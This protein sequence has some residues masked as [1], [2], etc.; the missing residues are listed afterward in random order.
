MFSLSRR[1]I[2]LAVITCIAAPLIARADDVVAS[3]VPSAA[4][5]ITS[6][7]YAP[8]EQ[9]WSVDA[10]R[11]LVIRASDGVTEL[12]RGTLPPNN[13]RQIQVLRDGSFI[14]SNGTPQWFERPQKGQ[15][16][17]LR[18]AFETL[19]KKVEKPVADWTRKE[20][21]SRE[22]LQ[23][24]LRSMP[25]VELAVSPDEKR[26]AEAYKAE[27]SHRFRS[28]AGNIVDFSADSRV[29]V[30][31]VWNLE[32]GEL[33]STRELW[34]T[35][36]LQWDLPVQMGWDNG[37]TSVYKT[38]IVARGLSVQRFDVT[39][40]AFVSE[41]KPRDAPDIL[42]RALNIQSERDEYLMWTRPVRYLPKR[43]L[44]SAK[45]DATPAEVF[46]EAGEN[47]V[48]PIQPKPQVTLGWLGKE[49]MASFN[50]A[51][52]R[53]LALSDDGKLL[54]AFDGAGLLTLWE[55]TTGRAQ[56]LGEFP[57]FTPSGASVSFEGR[58][59]AAWNGDVARVWR[60]QSE[61]TPRSERHDRAVTTLT[62]LQYG[63][64]ALSDKLWETQVAVAKGADR[65]LVFPYEF[66][67]GD[68]E[69]R[70]EPMRWEKLRGS[71]PTD[72]AEVKTP[73]APA[74][75]QAQSAT[76]APDGVTIWS[77]GSTGNL[78]IRSLKADQILLNE[79]L[80]P[81]SRRFRILYGNSFLVLSSWGDVLWYEQ[82][83]KGQPLKIKREFVRPEPENHY[84]RR[85]S[86]QETDKLYRHNYGVQE[87]G[88]DWALSPDGKLLAAST[89]F[90]PRHQQ[91][92]EEQRRGRMEWN[93]F[94]NF[95]SP[96]ATVSVW[97]LESG[98]LV[99][100]HR[101]ARPRVF[102]KTESEL[103]GSRIDF[104]ERF[105]S[106]PSGSKSKD[107]PAVVNLPA[108]DAKLSWDRYD[109]RNDFQT[110][111]INEGTTFTSVRFYSTN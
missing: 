98:K 103:Y 110:L 19:R 106:L 1:V 101:L 62:G 88:V 96:L 53:L 23:L 68:S 90:N 39:T 11:Q 32:S 33:E 9:L 28:N 93:P 50:V 72:A 111:N 49:W 37:N 79:K 40:G 83:V 57:G 78:Q 31:R 89:V 56:I 12:Y 64:I 22:L 77:L 42:A 67:S 94:S 55:T 69:L 7:I 8:N 70:A 36:R 14:V 38:L 92:Q 105:Y 82:P 15:P 59:V 65:V 107:T 16:L 46:N 17:K 80:P 58:I 95:S 2:L 51:E 20:F 109:Y 85:M 63:Q 48:T 76:Y 75:L 18:R 66:P 47:P 60:D 3:P 41:W 61:L 4:P 6:L 54:L 24:T 87:E 35:N 45:V 13:T 91:E 25:V 10:A 5:Q 100:Q 99:G 102:D 73:I 71:T 104:R 108:L 21:T 74:I 97:E 81:E 29:D 26:V 34:Q 43:I 86:Q 52:Q 30:I 27:T 44:P 84:S